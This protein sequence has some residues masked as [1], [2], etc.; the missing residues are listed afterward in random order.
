MA[1]SSG[2]IHR[3]ISCNVCAQAKFVQRTLHAFKGTE[4]ECLSS[5]CLLLFRDQ[6]GQR[7]CRRS[8]LCQRL[9][10]LLQ[11]QINHHHC[12][13][14][15]NTTDDNLNANGPCISRLMMCTLLN[16]AV[17]SPWPVLVAVAC[18]FTQPLRLNLFIQSNTRLS[19]AAAA[20]AAVL[21]CDVSLVNVQ[22]IECAFWCKMLTC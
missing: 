10:R 22:I 15:M 7:G 5:L 19:T 12:V 16:L 1:G 3:T 14:P 13:E 8:I 6:G 2:Q 17:H 20:A 4:Q 18:L 9:P 21:N 11:R